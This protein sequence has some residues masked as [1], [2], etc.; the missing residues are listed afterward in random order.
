MVCNP[1]NSV[2]N[3][4]FKY[5]NKNGTYRASA[6]RQIPRNGSLKYPVYTF[7][8]FDFTDGTMV[9]ESTQPVTAFLLYDNDGQTW[10]AGLSAKPVN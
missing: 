8:N 1:N 2:A 6:T 9:L 5:Y 3:I 7:F 4:T 10:K